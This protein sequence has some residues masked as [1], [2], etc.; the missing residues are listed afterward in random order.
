M[1]FSWKQESKYLMIIKCLHPKQVFKQV[2]LK[3]QVGNSEGRNKV[4]RFRMKRKQ[5]GQ[6]SSF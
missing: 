3:T 6:R 5:T 2:L 1:S 4:L